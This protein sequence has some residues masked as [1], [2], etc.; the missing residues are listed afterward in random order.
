MSS[1]NAS[2]ASVLSMRGLYCCCVSWR[3]CCGCRCCRSPPC[4][5][6]PLKS[7]AAPAATPNS[8]CLLEPV[9]ISV[10][11]KSSPLKSSTNGNYGRVL[12]ELEELR[13]DA[14]NAVAV[15]EFR[16]CFRGLGPFSCQET[17]A[18]GAHIPFYLFCIA[19]WTAW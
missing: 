3:C 8:P 9:V 18:P 2:C 12:C 4:Q 6:W 10:P 1:I 19:A 11:P 17:C 14:E 5:C 15:S 16:G 7:A 13:L